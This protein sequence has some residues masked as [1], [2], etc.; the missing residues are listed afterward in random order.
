[1]AM[2]D[3]SASAMLRMLSLKSFKRLVRKRGAELVDV[4]LPRI[5]QRD[6][7]RPVTMGRNLAVT[8]HTPIQLCL[9]G[10]YLMKREVLV[11]TS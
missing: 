6:S 5:Q 7:F 2:S 4:S 10:T 9:C 8:S 1:M 11:V 3:S